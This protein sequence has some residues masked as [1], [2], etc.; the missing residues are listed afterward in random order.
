[1][2]AIVNIASAVVSIVP[3]VAENEQRADQMLKS[4]QCHA[5]FVQQSYFDRTGGRE[6]HFVS[7]ASQ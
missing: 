2:S 1:M 6:Q 7:E 5:L 3:V 4:Y